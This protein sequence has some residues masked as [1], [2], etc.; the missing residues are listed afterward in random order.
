MTYQHKSSGKTDARL[1]RQQAKE[2]Q[3]LALKTADADTRLRFLHLA[4]LWTELANEA[5]QQKAEASNKEGAVIVFPKAVS[6]GK[7]SR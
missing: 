7:V 1:C 4:K 6:V 2:C 3:R 5:L